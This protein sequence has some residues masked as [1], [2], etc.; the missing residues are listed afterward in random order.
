M[1]LRSI[2]MVVAF[3]AA[4]AIPS[5]AQSQSDAY[6]TKPIRLVV[7]FAPGGLSDILARIMAARMGESLGTADGG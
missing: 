5:A 1:K 2:C 4:L 7:P 6:P 3:C